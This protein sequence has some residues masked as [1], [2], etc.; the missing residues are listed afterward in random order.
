M[1]KG[2]LAEYY[3]LLAT[4]ENC[5]LLETSLPDASNRLSFL[6]LAPVEI[7]QIF[8]LS[9]LPGLLDAIEGYTGQGYYTAGYFGYECGYYIEKLGLDQDYKYERP[10][11]WFGIYHKPL[12]FE[13]DR[14]TPPASP[15]NF[16]STPGSEAGYR[17]SDIEFNLSEA[18]YAEKVA[19][20]KEYIKAGDTY[21]INFTGAY[22]FKF[23]GSPLALYQVLQQKQPVSYGAYI[24]AAGQ[25]ILSFSPELFFRIDGQQITTRPMKGTIGRGMTLAED[26]QQANWLQN[27]EKNRAEN[28][29]IVD[30][31]RNDIGRLSETGSVKVTELFTVERY[32][33]LFQ[34]TSTVQGTLK[35]GW[36][37]RE[38]FESLFPCGSVTGA[39]KIRAMQIIKQLETQPRGVYT[40][41][42]GYFGPDYPTQKPGESPSRAVFN[43]A[44]RTI[45]LTGSKGVMGIG[46]GIVDDSVA[47]EEYR[48]CTL[49]AR[50][51]TEPALAF[52]ILEAVLW[53]NGYRW[54][55]RH[56]DR[57]AQAAAYFGYFYDREYL[58]GLL[59]EQESNFQSGGRYKVRLILARNGEASCEAAE[60]AQPLAQGRLYVSISPLRVDSRNRFSYYK[61]TNRAVYDQA[62]ARA[63]KEGYADI[64]FLNE[65]GEV[66]EGA[67]NNIFIEKNGQLFTPPRHCGLLNG[68]YRQHVLA[69]NP[70]ASEKV[71]S[72]ADLQEAD[73]LFIC[74]SIRGWRKVVLKPE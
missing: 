55:D 12:I 11:A 5:V 69:E 32:N 63:A 52:S 18:A 60:L 73:N 23:E 68:V 72:T 4:A 35:V 45:V 33:T 20:V 3:N 58:R 9:E 59:A 53:D 56:L 67:T 6:F 37:Y 47:A 61:T 26:I 57:M 31:L 39:P 49:K 14:E 1:F 44:I 30:L 46:S 51:L 71:L 15:G 8:K 19:Q 13:Q 17:L 24:Q 65:K 40:G 41:S 54:L 43:V 21:Q 66:T 16:A 38:L 10:L 74:N 27:D 25:H 48:E 29:M 42:I 34:M 64:I 22:K 50:F 7:L 70:A 28:I 2:S 36:R 62:S